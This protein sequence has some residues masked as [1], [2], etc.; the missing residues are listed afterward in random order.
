MTVNDLKELLRAAGLATTGNKSELILRLSQLSANEMDK[1]NEIQASQEV[2]E[3][4]VEDTSD[5]AGAQDEA[6]INRRMVDIYKR[7]KELAERELAILRRELELER[8]RTSQAGSNTGAIR[9]SSVT[10]NASLLQTPGRVSISAVAD[11]LNSFDGNAEA[12]ETWEKQVLFLRESY[13]LDDAMTKILIGMRLKGKALEW[14]HSAP[15]YIQLPTDSLLAS[16]R[17]MFFHRTNK[18]T[19]RRR[20]EERSWKRTETFYEYV[21]EKT[22]MGNRI[23]IE[24]D[25]LLGYVIDGI[26]DSNLRN[27]ARTHA[28]KAKEEL[29][30]AFE[31]ISLQDPSGTTTKN[32][33]NVDKKNSDKRGPTKDAKSESGEGSASRDSKSSANKKNRGNSKRCFNCGSIEHLSA[34]CPT[35]ERGRKCFKCGGHGHIAVECPENPKMTRSTRLI[36]EPSPEKRVK[37]IHIDGQVVDAI[38]DT[39]SDLTLMRDDQY[40]EMS[41]P[42]LI[43]KSIPFRGVGKERNETIGFFEATLRVDDN[44]YEVRVYVVKKDL[45]DQRLLLGTDFLDNVQLIR[46]RDACTIKPLKNENDNDVIPE[47]LR[48][49]MIDTN[50]ADVAMINDVK[51]RERKLRV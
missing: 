44:N 19:L 3:I 27:L 17:G 15:Q 50:E 21:H 29:L 30:L 12:F 2:R 4:T 49:Q 36:A 32:R 51:Y 22:I 20:F 46:T 9:R 47:V 28:F 33:E 23:A 26:P 18:I 48:I 41:L 8:A 14:F 1:V 42:K 37:R 40:A 11:L 10:P 7:E 43:S 34:N 5:N 25:E 24:E 13:E 31:G 39:A 35:K 45:L 38:M 16:L 6:S